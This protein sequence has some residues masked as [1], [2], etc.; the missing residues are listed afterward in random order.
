MGPE[1]I[2]KLA[3]ENLAEISDESFF[4]SL[5]SVS[6]IALQI[7]LKEENGIDLDLPD[8]SH[9]TSSKDISDILWPFLEDKEAISLI[10]SQFESMKAIRK[11]E[12]EHSDLS[13]ELNIKAPS[14]IKNILSSPISQPHEVKVPESEMQLDAIAKKLNLGLIFPA[15]YFARKVDEK[16]S[17][18]TYPFREVFF[19]L[20]QESFGFQISQNK[21]WDALIRHEASNFERYP[22]FIEFLKAQGLNSNMML[23]WN[24]IK[25]DPTNLSFKPNTLFSLSG[26]LGGAFMLKDAENNP[27]LVVKPNAC[28]IHGPMNTKQCASFI[29][30]GEKNPKFMA[31]RNQPAFTQIA[32]AAGKL[33][34]ENFHVKK[35]IPE[36]LGAQ[37][38]ACAY[39]IALV[40]GL[41]HITPF[42]GIAI[43]ESTDVKL[44]SEFVVKK[45]AEDIRKYE[46]TE[47]KFICSIQPFIPNSVS[48]ASYIGSSRKTFQEKKIPENFIKLKFERQFSYKNVEDI[49]L[50]EMLAGECDPNSGNYLVVNDLKNKGK[51]QI[52][53]I[54]NALTFSTLHSDFA[55]GKLKKLHVLTLFD[56]FPNFVRSSISEDGR[57]KIKEIIGKKKEII[58]V[59]N[60]FKKSKEAIQAF[61]ERLDMLGK[62]CDTYKDIT[63]EELYISMGNTDQNFLRDPRETK[64]EE[65]E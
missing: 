8:F 51:K 9:V 12:V 37:N 64:E 44:P 50:F 18:I 21:D 2:E 25:Q 13:V 41:E 56:T 52:L 57:N 35:G 14:Y 43:V 49:L 10:P 24:L 61:E 33:Q 4:G 58:S 15:L 39:E 65:E 11:P 60:K 7:I 32:E 30:G 27:R 38:E 63:L 46:P 31:I 5:F 62:L 19:S 55:N 6:L 1:L 29:V 22:N 42:V 36:G 54:D 53:K 20:V 34:D 45:V 26:G 23:A 47:R 16:T 40:A 3:Q 48:I 28:D 59:L 17:A